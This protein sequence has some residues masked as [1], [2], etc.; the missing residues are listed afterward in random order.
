MSA[1]RPAS[2]ESPPATLE[3]PHEPTSREEFEEIFGSEIV[4]QADRVVRDA[5]DSTTQRRSFFRERDTIQACHRTS[6]REFEL[7]VLEHP[8]FETMLLTL[9]REFPMVTLDQRGA[10]TTPEMWDIERKMLALAGERTEEHIVPAELVDKALATRTWIASNSLP[11]EMVEHIQRENP[12]IKGP[13]LPV[14][15]VVSMALRMGF[16]VYGAGMTWNRA[17]ATGISDDLIGDPQEFLQAM[18]DSAAA[19]KDWFQKPTLFVSDDWDSPEAKALAAH[20]EKTDQPVIL[21]PRVGIS[22]EQV[23]ALIAATLSDKRVPVIEGTAGAGKSFTMKSVYEAYMA[24]GYDVMG[25]ALGWSAAKVLS[26]STGLPE[27]SCRALAGF[28]GSLKRAEARGT[29]FFTRPT[30]IIVDE[31]G[32]VGTRFMHDLL[33]ITRRSRYPVK[34]VLTGDSL[35]VAPV[36]A[37]NAMEAIIHH[38]GTTRINTIRRQR[39]ESH[40]T[41]VHRFSEQQSGKALYPFIH[42]EAIRWGKDKEDMFNQVVR[43]FISYRAAFPEKK[44]LILA[45]K[46]EDVTEL[47]RRIRLVY[48]KAGF[49][50]PN[51]VSLE[52]TDGQR[53]WRAGFSVGDEVQIRANDQN[54]P[55]YYVPK[56]GTADL[57]DESTW[58]FKTTGVFNRNSGRIV[59]IRRAERPAGSYDFIVDLEGED[60]ASRVIVNSQTFKH[61]SSRG[62][63]MV[64]NFATTIYASQGMT[65]PKV[66]L[67]DS[68]RMNFRL[69]YVGMSRHTE[70]VD[71]YVNETDLHLRL[72]GILGKSPSRPTN[73]VNPDDIGVE[74]GRYSRMEM[75]QTMALT[76]GQDSENLTATMYEIRART[77]YRSYEE[78]QREEALR[79]KIVPGS[80]DEPVVDFVPEVNV[81]YPLVDLEKIL[82]IPD[83][84]G[85]AEFVRPSDTEANRKAL[86]T[87]ESPVRLKAESSLPD[88]PPVDD[89]DE[90]VFS[91]AASWLRGGPKARGPSRK[92]ASSPAPVSRGGQKKPSSPFKEGSARLPSSVE[93]AQTLVGTVVKFFAS[94]TPRPE[95]LADLPFLPT[96]KSLGRVD[97]KGVL[98]FDGVP[99]T[100]APE[101]V[102]IPSASDQFLSSGPGRLWWDVGRGG[103]PRVL[104]RWTHGQ[105]MARY[106][107]DGKCVVGDGFPPVAFNPSPN[108]ET[109][110][111]IVPGPREWLMMQEKYQEKF[112]DS[113]E[114]M[115]HLVWGAE[116]VDWKHIAGLIKSRPVVI[117]RSRYDN[118]Q[119]PW[120]T[121]LHKELTQRWGLSVSVAPKIPDLDRGSA[122]APR[123]RRPG[124]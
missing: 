101:G 113:P 116:D 23:D 57:Y 110:V 99:Q 90:G 27:K 48:K 112:K 37:G 82:R 40:R 52:I 22:D 77:Q 51:E 41:A 97:E 18:N 38:H 66:L 96:P 50:E 59:G 53:R 115:P 47:N 1:F 93:E 75:L 78:K 33:A 5:I 29:Q 43:D 89:P 124:P 106:S 45:L 14:S 87:Y 68:E 71:V 35:Q 102:E 121:D 15:E 100:K 122:P 58:E 119:I 118:D 83:P 6:Q 49:I 69:S 81:N 103:E 63:P 31:A 111:H 108:E 3:H 36:D 61:E 55:V 11:Q 54:L 86:P 28:L 26:G 19:N 16:E 123:I 20:A 64:H 85:Q 17:G 114:K 70:S 95:G 104:A 67:V 60:G 34:I 76:W 32:M 79:A 88:L 46:N 72:D 117:L 73:R 92:A 98:R 62:M 105:V 7:S 25:A 94:A 30:L 21:A 8:H 107:L 42:Q 44:A 9:F 2:A 4:A 24:M 80:L 56:P 65:V 12:S 10:I 91:K 39:Q 109:P 74:L 13:M 84:I 120:A